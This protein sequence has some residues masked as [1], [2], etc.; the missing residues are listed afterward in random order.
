MAYYSHIYIYVY[1]LYEKIKIHIKLSGFNLNSCYKSWPQHPKMKCFYLQELSIGLEKKR[2]KK[3]ITH[4]VLK[5]ML[6][7]LSKC[8]SCCVNWSIFEYIVKSKDMEELIIAQMFPWENGPL[9]FILNFCSVWVD[10]QMNI[11]FITRGTDYHT[12]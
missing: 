2:K 1:T 4:T 6:R 11:C 8:V 7:I 12:G 5:T 3:K 9:G 10:F